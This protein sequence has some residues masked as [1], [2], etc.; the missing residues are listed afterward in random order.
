MIKYSKIHKKIVTSHKNQYYL[1][2]L[3]HELIFKSN[4]KNK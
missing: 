1:S 2:V 3:E 4:S